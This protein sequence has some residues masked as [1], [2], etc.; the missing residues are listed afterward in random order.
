MVGKSSQRF[1]RF[2]RRPAL[3]LGGRAV[4]Q[5]PQGHFHSNCRFEQKGMKCYVCVR[6][7]EWSKSTISLPMA[8]TDR[9][10]TESI[11]EENPPISLPTA[12]ISLF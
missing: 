10:T 1:V 8:K 2:I 4:V 12:T 9:Q 7:P 5:A 11:V 3:K 6:V